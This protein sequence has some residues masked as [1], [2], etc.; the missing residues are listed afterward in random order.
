MR[1][2][3]CRSRFR[4]TGKLPRSLRPSAVTSSLASTVPRPGTPVDHRVGPV[5]QAVAVDHV[6]ALARRQRRPLPAV[7]EIACAGLEFGD[8]LGDRARLV[9]GG[10]EPGVVDLQEDPLRPLVELDVG[11]GEAA[12]G[13]VAEAQP[14][15]LAPEV[16]DVGLGAGARVGAGLHRVLLGGQ[17]ERVEAQR[18]QHVAA[19]HPEVAGVDVGGDVAERVT[20]VQPLARRVR[21]HVLHEHLV[22]GHRRSVRRRQRADRVG[23]VERPQP[24]PVVLPGVLRCGRPAPRCSGTAGASASACSAGGGRGVGHVNRV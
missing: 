12:P 23:H 10:V 19:R 16:D 6:G 4:N 3:H 15:Q 13:V 17:A 8:Q 1:I 11:G 9:G 14:A 5:H 24:G 20:D 18:V 2:I 21:E 22:V 7:V